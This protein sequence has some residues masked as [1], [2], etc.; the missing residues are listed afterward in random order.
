MRLTDVVLP[1]GPKELRDV[2]MNTDLPMLL[3]MLKKEIKTNKRRYI[4]M[5]LAQRINKLRGDQF[6]RESLE[7]I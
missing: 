3:L 6:M 1:S 2:I 4:V 5:R 7:K